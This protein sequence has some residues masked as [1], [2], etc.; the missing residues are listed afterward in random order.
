MLDHH[1]ASRVCGVAIKG[2]DSLGPL[3][4]SPSF[5]TTRSIPHSTLIAIRIYAYIRK[6]LDKHIHTGRPPLPLPAR[7]AHVHAPGPHRVSTF[8][9]VDSAVVSDVS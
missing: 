6:H 5:P 1:L 8:F 7:G 3:M 9:T 2:F 4:Q